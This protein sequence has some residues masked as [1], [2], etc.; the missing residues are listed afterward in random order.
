MAIV[1]IEDPSIF[2][3]LSY[4]DARNQILGYGYSARLVWADK[5]TI[6]LDPTHEYDP[7]RI[8]LWVEKSRVIKALV[9]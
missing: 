2:V 9:G 6:V 3:G 8:N 4:D 1:K 5:R 7:L